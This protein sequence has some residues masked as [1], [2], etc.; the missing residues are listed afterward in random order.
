MWIAIPS[1]WITQN[2]LRRQDSAGFSRFLANQ[3]GLELVFLSGCANQSETEELIKAGVPAVISTLGSTR[4]D[5]AR[6]FAI[7]FY[8]SIGYYSPIEEAFQ[9]AEGVVIGKYGTGLNNLYAEEASEKVSG[10]P[11]RLMINKQNE[12]AQWRL[13]EESFEP[14]QDTG[15]LT[16]REEAYL[17]CSRFEQVF[18]FRDLLK[19]EFSGSVRTPFSVVIYGPEEELPGSLAR[20][21]ILEG[22]D[23]LRF[24]LNDQLKH[25]SVIDSFI[26]IRPEYFTKGPES[27]R[28][29]VE[30]QMARKFGLKE[31]SVWE[32]VSRYKKS[33]IIFLTHSFHG[34]LNKEETNIYADYLNR[35]QQIELSPK[36]PMVI[37]LNTF[38]ETRSNLRGILNIFSGDPFQRMIDNLGV[39]SANILPRLSPVSREDVQ[40]WQAENLPESEYLPDEIFGNKKELPMIE[41]E[42][43]LREEI[44]RYFKEDL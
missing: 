43:A 21:L 12:D 29:G 9:E 42:P 37:I 14:I 28:Y 1:F 25:D 16:I 6:D 15:P 33:K 18:Q 32:L 3:P 11:W 22:S 19:K 41:V 13:S 30:S 38:H 4:D 20:R 34:T 40:V 10:L 35:F 2:H 24:L 39:D 27:F 36:D 26:D 44:E 7:N 23:L 8:R 17:F 5:I 31:F